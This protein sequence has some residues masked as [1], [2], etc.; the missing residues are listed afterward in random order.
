MNASMRV[1]MGACA[2]TV[3]TASGLRLMDFENQTAPAEPR[4]GSLEPPREGGPSTWPDAWLI[5]AVRR[6]PLD[7]AS[8]DA[9][10]GRYWKA[11]FARCQILTIDRE[12]ASD[13]AQD[14]W[15]RVL[16]ARHNLEPD[17]NFHAY[18]ITIA[19]NLWRDRNRSTQRAGA[20]ATTRLASLDSSAPNSDG[21]GMALVDA[22]ADP[23]SLSMD[24]QVVLKMDMDR[25]L[26]QLSAQLRDVLVSR[27]VG[28]ESAAEIGRR[29]GRTEQ[30]ISG[31][32]REAVRELKAHLGDSY[33][34]D[35]PSEKR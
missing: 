13:L 14:A 23:H 12:S 11:L 15:L 28:G 30:T 7:E 8:L 22:L 3:F 1:S 5:N 29:Y 24:D 4:V 34:L 20:M 9:L 26:H 10:V 35:A 17:G 18:I 25:A 19:T 16:R 2:H 33:R 6:D 27:F 31:W 21:E 32:V